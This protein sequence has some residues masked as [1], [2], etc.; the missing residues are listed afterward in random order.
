MTGNDADMID[1]PAALGMASAILIVLVAGAA[2]VLLPVGFLLGTAP[3][4]TAPS[5]DAAQHAVG[6]WYFMADAWRLPL[7]VVPHLGIPGGT[8]IA[9]TDSI[10][11]AA[12]LAKLARG[13]LGTGQVYL[14]PW[15]FLCFLLQGPAAAT[16]LYVCGVRRV[17]LLVLGG[18]L[19]LGSPVL[20]S[21]I[22]HAALCGQFLVLFALAMHIRLTRDSGPAAILLYLPLLAASV[23]THVYLFA[24]VAALF[25]ASLL[26]ALWTDRMA[27][28][29]ALGLLVLVAAPLVGMLWVCG[30]FGLGTIPI[31]PYGEWAFDLAAPF[32]PSFSLLFGV[33]R[34][35]AGLDVETLAWMGAGQAA[36]LVV[37]AITWR[38][39]IAGLLARHAASV[40]V[41]VVLVLFATSYAVHVAGHVVLG[42]DPERLRAAALA[43]QAGTGALAALRADLG[44]VDILRGVGLVVLVGGLVVWGVGHAVARCRWR[45]LRGVGVVGAALLVLAVFQPRALLV[46]ISTFQA[47]AR[48]IWVPIYLFALLAVVAICR[49]FSPG[50]ATAVLTAALLVQVADTLALWRSLR[51]HA[52]SGGRAAEQDSPLKA[53]IAAASDVRVVPTYLCAHVEPPTLRAE[54]IARIVDVQVLAAKAHRPIDSVRSSRMTAADVPALEASCAAAARTVTAEIDRP[55]RLT[56]VAAD[57]P[58]TVALRAT[59][60]GRAACRA[61]S[62]WVYCLPEAA[63]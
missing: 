42:V 52:Y 7:L 53:A 1:R 56:I 60:A 19:M 41:G 51:A 63:R 49:R 38:T 40:I 37:A 33:P 21:R 25:G 28:R 2:L 58:G 11:L 16:V 32:L 48:L 22:G 14:G 3:V 46:G 59:I 4:W 30:Y 9:L 17:V 5:G 15:L 34:M 23:L 50:V 12:L 24:M 18:L 45:A 43:A 39:E 6:G 31:K 27:A 10:P 35:P 44:T 57:T 26:D 20:V 36:L 47:S 29:A 54:L 62:G 55:G 8:N 13:A 61:V